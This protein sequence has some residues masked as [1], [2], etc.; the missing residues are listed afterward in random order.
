MTA[1]IV[2]LADRRQ[3]ARPAPL[4]AAGAG[5]AADAAAML[6]AACRA[7][8][9]ALAQVGASSATARDQMSRLQEGAVAAAAGAGA[10][11]AAVDGV[12][13]LGRSLREATH[14]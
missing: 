6:G 10:V 11:I 12:A 9:A 7:L 5:N 14:G 2:V 13:G 4:A 8:A 1:E 3:A